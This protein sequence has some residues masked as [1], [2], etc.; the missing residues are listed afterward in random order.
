MQDP[1]GPVAS[2][3]R[4][5]DQP[6]AREGSWCG[7]RGLDWAAI[8]LRIVFLISM[9]HDATHEYPGSAHKGAEAYGII[10]VD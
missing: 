8:L 7:S 10:T 2:A 4:H 9:D 1:Q 3:M 6:S 5:E